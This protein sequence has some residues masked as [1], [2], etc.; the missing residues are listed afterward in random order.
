MHF[1]RTSPASVR[2]SERKM[3]KEGENAK[4]EGERRQE[5]YKNHKLAGRYIS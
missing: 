4:G 2:E 3:W 1:I 5:G